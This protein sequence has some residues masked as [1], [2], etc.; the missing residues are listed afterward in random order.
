MFFN[1]NS[2][3]RLSLTSLIALSLAA[4]AVAQDT[5]SADAA[6]KE[7]EAMIGGVPSVMKMYPKAGVAGAWVVQRGLILGETS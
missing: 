5:T 6:F 2:I 1:V 4:P 3:S 7:M